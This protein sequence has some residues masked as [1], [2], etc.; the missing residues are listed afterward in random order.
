M[1]SESMIGLKITRPFFDEIEFRESSEMDTQKHFASEILDRFNRFFREIRIHLE[2]GRH[3]IASECK[4]EPDFALVNSDS[5]LVCVIEIKTVFTLDRKLISLNS[6]LSPAES[7]V[8]HIIEQLM[9]YMCHNRLKYALLSSFENTWFC[10]RDDLD[11][12]FSP[13]VT[14]DS[15]DPTL[16][17]CI[18]YFVLALVQNQHTEDFHS[19]VRHSIRISSDTNT[20]DSHSNTEYS[21]DVSVINSIPEDFCVDDL[22]DCIGNGYCGNVYKS[23][24]RGEAVAVKLCDVYNNKNGLNALKN[25]VL[26]YEKLKPIQGDFIPRLVFFGE[27]SGFFMVATTYIQSARTPDINE[28]GIRNKLEEIEKELLKYGV[29]HGDLR[30]ENIIIDAHEKVHVIDFSHS[31]FIRAS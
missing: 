2:F 23:F 22:C 20:L 7:S 19:S 1:E 8:R 14:F 31:E 11:L 21:S 13:A 9:G 28:C 12:F 25:E 27:S 15:S 18:G 26:I 24:F 6:L 16:F 30:K 4:G 10:Y 5:E 3:S 29:R 17:R